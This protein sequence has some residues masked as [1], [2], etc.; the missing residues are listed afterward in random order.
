MP[1]VIFFHC[2]AAAVL[3]VA[4]GSIE[5]L[6][7][8]SRRAVVGRP[9]F[10]MA[11]H[12]QMAPHIVDQSKDLPTLFLDGPIGPNR[13]AQNK[14]YG[15]CDLRDREGEVD[16][17]VHRKQEMRILLADASLR[18]IEVVDLVL[19]CADVWLLLEK[20]EG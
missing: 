8:L 3:E 16:G 7:R 11:A 14:V 1:F 2:S 19:S 20:G 9:K 5:V 6:G 12:D 18:T 13:A 17:I 10:W 4:L 15:I